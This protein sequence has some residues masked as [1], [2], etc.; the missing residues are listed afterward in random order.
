[1][2]LLVIVFVTFIGFGLTNN[3]IFAQA[4]DPKSSSACI[5]YE[6]DEERG[7]NLITISCLQPITLTDISNSI[8]NQEILKKED[9][10]NTHLDIRCNHSSRK[11]FNARD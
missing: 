5:N 8:Q 7:R 2:C 10:S 9:N 1:M 6:F 3:Q 4:S 11:R